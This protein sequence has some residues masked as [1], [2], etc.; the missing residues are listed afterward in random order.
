MDQPFTITSQHA[1]GPLWHLHLSPDHENRRK[2]TKHKYG[3]LATSVFY[4]NFFGDFFSDRNCFR[5]KNLVQYFS[6][7]F[8]E[9]FKK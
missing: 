5:K 3:D 2:R 4:T 6:I 9:S 7:P 8:S 1:T